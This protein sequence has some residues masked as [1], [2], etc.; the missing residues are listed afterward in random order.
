MCYDYFRWTR[1]KFR[2]ICNVGN[3]CSNLHTRLSTDFVD[4]FKYEPYT[5][6]I[7]NDD[8][9]NAYLARVLERIKACQ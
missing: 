4:M 2:Y 1:C 5:D 3:D 7:E 9:L 6:S 8:A